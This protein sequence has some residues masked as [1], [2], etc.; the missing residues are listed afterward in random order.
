MGR[1]ARR[2]LLPAAPPRAA[3]PGSRHRESCGVAVI[4]QV[5]I[6]R[7]TDQ[8]ER[9]VRFYRDGLGLPVLGGFGPDAGVGPDA[10]GGLRVHASACAAG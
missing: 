2:A 5:R 1:A 3:P 8:L 9:V 4:A 10:S 7:P 6:R